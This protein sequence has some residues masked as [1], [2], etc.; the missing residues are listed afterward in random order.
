MTFQKVVSAG[1]PILPGHLSA[2][3]RSPP[4]IN[5]EFGDT[6]TP[7][8]K[9]YWIFQFLVKICTFHLPAPGRNQLGI[10]QSPPG[11]QPAEVETAAAPPLIL[12]EKSDSFFRISLLS[13]VGQFTSEIADEL[14]INLSNDRSHLRQT[15]S[16]IGIV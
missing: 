7:I 3:K 8:C 16:K 4:H 5:I 13:H 6:S 14:R 15:Y 10:P 9:S 11:A 12:F 1:A 2:S